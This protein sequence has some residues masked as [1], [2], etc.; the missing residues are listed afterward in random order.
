M[1][2]SGDSGTFE[3]DLRDLRDAEIDAI[4]S[5]SSRAQSCKPSFGGPSQSFENR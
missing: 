1:F 2:R 3:K 5:V 4:F